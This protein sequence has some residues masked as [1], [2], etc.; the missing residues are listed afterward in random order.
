MKSSASMEY[1]LQQL[2]ALP[3][4]SGSNAGNPSGTNAQNEPSL[5]MESHSNTEWKPSNSTWG[6]LAEVWKGN[7]TVP[8]STKTVESDV[9]AIILKE[10]QDSE[11]E[12]ALKNLNQCSVRVYT[13]GDNRIDLVKTTNSLS[14]NPLAQFN[15]SGAWHWFLITAGLCLWGLAVLIVLNGI[16]F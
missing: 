2:M 4:A 9:S 10:Y 5:S 12:H 14:S 6:P 3:S 11:N 15:F 8:S 1:M 7:G 16:G 13:T